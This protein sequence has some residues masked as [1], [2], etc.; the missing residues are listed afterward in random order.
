MIGVSLSM[1]TFSISLSI[2]TFNITRKKTLFLCFLVGIMHFFM[3]LIGSILG[4]KIVTFLNINVNFL[5]GLILLFIGVE[6]IIDLTKKEDKYFE[7]NLFNMILVSLSVSLDS[8]ST[9][10][11]LSAITNDIFL[12]GIIF[13]VCAAAFTFLGLLIGKYSGE[14][15]GIYANL[16]GIALLIILGLMHIF[17]WFWIK[18]IY[19]FQYINKWWYFEK[20]NK[21]I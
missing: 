20:E 10:L 4:A 3:P 1:D 21:S 14:K 15:L 19:F 2:G 8:F 6:M 12:S 7:L 18:F 5:L 13:S 16:F 11:G 17:N 9:G